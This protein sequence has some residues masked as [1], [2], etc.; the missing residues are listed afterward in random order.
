VQLAE[1]LLEMSLQAAKA[2]RACPIP[3]QHPEQ[4]IELTGVGP[5]VVGLILKR[6]KKHC[7]DT[8]EVMPDRSKHKHTLTPSWFA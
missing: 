4:A 3:F 2:L 7:Q 1:I 6:L 5:T 8:G